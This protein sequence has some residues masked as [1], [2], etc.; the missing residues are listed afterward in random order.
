MFFFYDTTVREK[1]QVLLLTVLK[2]TRYLDT[3]DIFVYD[4]KKRSGK[5]KTAER[6]FYVV[7]L[8]FGKLA[9]SRA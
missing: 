9:K 7:S 1:C 3:A 2:K 6:G 4:K 5:I 8:F